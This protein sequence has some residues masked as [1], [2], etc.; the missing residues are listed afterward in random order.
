MH[1]KSKYR[2][3]I[4][5]GNYTMCPLVLSRLFNDF[6]VGCILAEFINAFELVMN[7][8]Y[9]EYNREKGRIYE[10]Y[11]EYSVENMMNRTGLKK[12]K[13]GAAKKKLIDIG[14]IEFKLMGLPARNYF[15]FGKHFD[16]I[17]SHIMEGKSY[18]ELIE[19][20]TSLSSP[21]IS[22]LMAENQRTYYIEKESKKNTTQFFDKS[23]KIGLRDDSF[24][25]SNN[26][27]ESI[28]KEIYKIDGNT[29]QLTTDEIIKYNKIINRGG[30]LSFWKSVYDIVFIAMGNRSLLDKEG[31][32]DGQDINAINR[33]IDL[34][35]SN[36]TLSK[37]IKFINHKFKENKKGVLEYFPAEILKKP[38]LKKFNWR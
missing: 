18:Q 6:N 23:E 7:P 5:Q 2:E 34:I 17:F 30:D 21:K 37:F 26:N 36:G 10:D 25:I 11:V 12:H 4:T 15:R 28:L 24:F 1:K 9:I 33:A 29:R 38:E 3:L 35:G 8:D 19:I 32:F 16:E 27:I 13:L 20:Y 14:L 31:N 22:E